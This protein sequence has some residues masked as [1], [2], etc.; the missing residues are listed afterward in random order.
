VN[1]VEC[2]TKDPKQ[3][4]AK[5]SGQALGWLRQKLIPQA[6]MPAVEVRKVGAQTS[7][8]PLMAGKAR[9]VAPHSTVV[10]VQSLK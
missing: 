2:E 4:S 7:C 3:A 6:S 10:T 9:S 1:T 5:R 8:R